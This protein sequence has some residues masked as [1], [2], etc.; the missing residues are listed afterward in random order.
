MHHLAVINENQSPSA[1]KWYIFLQKDINVMMMFV[2]A[3]LTLDLGLYAKLFM[4]T[5][6]QPWWMDVWL[7]GIKGKMHP[8]L[9][10]LLFSG[11]DRV[12]HII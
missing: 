10:Q 6:D 5:S 9:H 7:L 2:A 1:R 11:E 12:S 3:M 8:N 4:I